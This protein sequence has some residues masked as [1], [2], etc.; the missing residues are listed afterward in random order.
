LIGLP[1]P[2]RRSGCLP[3][4]HARPADRLP[5]STLPGR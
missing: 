5:A 3:I 1:D 4:G 2:A